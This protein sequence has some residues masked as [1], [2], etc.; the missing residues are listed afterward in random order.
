MTLAKEGLREMLVCTLLFGVSGA[1]CA[2]AAWSV[3]WL[4]AIPAA[5]LI[6]L[7]V[8]CIAFFRDPVRTIPSEPGLL[9]S[10]ADGKVTEVSRL[11]TY[12]GI[13][14]E[15]W[16]ISIFLSVFDV[17]I[18]RSPCDGNIVRTDYRPGEFLDARHPESGIRNESNTIIIDPARD[19]RDPTYSLRGPVIVRQVAGL[20]ARRII[21]RVQVGDAI[22]RGQR[23]GLIKFGS[24]TDLILPAIAGL[25]PTVKLNDVVRGGSSVLMRYQPIRQEAGAA[26]QPRDNVTA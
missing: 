17:H 16:K 22:S 20:I 18:N 23:M 13:D 12:D 3:S 19:G 5:P 10:P 1:T 26:R 4:W 9:V 14:G 25:E 6:A 21:C 8:F 15:A 24:R 7:W 2:W 11:P